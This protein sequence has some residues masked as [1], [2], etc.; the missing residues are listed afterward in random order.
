MPLT[1]LT[2][3]MKSHRILFAA[4]ESAQSKKPVK[5]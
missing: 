3:A 2:E 4:D 1:N 5:V